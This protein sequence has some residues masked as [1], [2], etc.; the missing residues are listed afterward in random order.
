MNRIDQYRTTMVFSDQVLSSLCHSE[1]VNSKLD[2]DIHWYRLMSSMIVPHNATLEQHSTPKLK[3]TV[4][5]QRIMLF[6]AKYSCLKKYSNQGMTL[7]NRKLSAKIDYLVLVCILQC[8]YYILKFSVYD[9]WITIDQFTHYPPSCLCSTAIPKAVRTKW[10]STVKTC[11]PSR[12][13]LLYTRP[14]S[15]KVSATTNVKRRYALSFD[16]VRMKMVHTTIRDW[17]ADFIPHMRD[18]IP[19]TK[20]KIKPSVGQIWL[21]L[22]SAMFL[23]W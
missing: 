5:L 7:S 1:P 20:R 23:M 3:N 16:M 2:L 6:K 12:R 18:S 11:S 21:K 4:I 15:R 22:R 9:L 14:L 19:L 13:L 8:S 10:H 17:Q